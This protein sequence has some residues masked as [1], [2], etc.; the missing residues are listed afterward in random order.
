[1]RRDMNL[2]VKMSGSLDSVQTLIS[3]LSK[4]QQLQLRWK[5]EQGLWANMLFLTAKVTHSVFVHLG[6]HTCMQGSRWNS[7]KPKTEVVFIFFFL[8]V[9]KC[10]PSSGQCKQGKSQFSSLFEQ[11]CIYYIYRGF[12]VHNRQMFAIFLNWVFILFEC[13]YFSPSKAYYELSQTK[14]RIVPVRACWRQTV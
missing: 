11:L 5:Q 1:M 10:W 13:Y 12:K 3:R 2:R 14:L 4:F 9:N 8:G 6:T 7:W